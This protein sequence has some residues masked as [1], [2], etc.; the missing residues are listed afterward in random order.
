MTIP[1]IIAGILAFLGQLSDCIT[2]QIALAHG[3][4]E[5]NPLMVWVTRHVFVEYTL[6][7]GMALTLL[8]VCQKKFAPA[9]SGITPLLLA[10]AMGFIAAIWNMSVLIRLFYVRHPL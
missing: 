4:H 5:A 2:T 1:Y 10:A 6:K 8:F 9:R 7:L 3:A